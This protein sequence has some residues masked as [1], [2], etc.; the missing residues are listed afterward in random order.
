MKT[1]EL[2]PQERRITEHV[3]HLKRA[4]RKIGQRWA[5]SGTGKER[6]LVCI[7]QAINALNCKLRPHSL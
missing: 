4:R 1:K 2:T 5:V 6:R 7:K 3:S